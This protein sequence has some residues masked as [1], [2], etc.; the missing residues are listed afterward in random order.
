MILCSMNTST[1]TYT[2]YY[3]GGDSGKL[4]AHDIYHTTGEPRF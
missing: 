2:N 4:E 3:G 1:S